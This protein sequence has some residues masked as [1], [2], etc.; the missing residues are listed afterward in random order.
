MIQKQLALPQPVII[1]E[2]DF[3]NISL[4]NHVIYQKLSKYPVIN[5]DISIVVNNSVL[6]GD[7]VNCIGNTASNL[8]KNLQLF[9]VYQGEPI[10]IG[11]K[12]L[13]LGLTFQGYSS[14]LTDQEIDRII[15]TII[16]RLNDEFGATLRE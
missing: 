13:A 15:E 4:H 2:L 9:D 12:S 3:S 7:I 10:D 16:N 14:T 8:L 11:K 1:F 6:L 5:R